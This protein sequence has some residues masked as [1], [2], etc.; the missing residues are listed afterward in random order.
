MSADNTIVILGTLRD[1]KK[2]YRV[3]HIGNIDNLDYY[4]EHQYYN[5]GWYLFTEF[6][7]CVVYD[8]IN[9]AQEVAHLEYDLCSYVEYGVVLIDLDII[10]PGD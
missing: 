5:F 3:A 2:V 1:N 7:D 4:K 10:F 8:D 9:M 6:G